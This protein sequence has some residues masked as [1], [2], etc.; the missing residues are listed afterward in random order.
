[1]RRTDR[2]LEA[3]KLAM[4]AFAAEINTGQ[5]AVKG[6]TFRPY[7][8]DPDFQFHLYIAQ[9]AGN[10]YFFDI[11]STLGPKLIPRSRFQ[12]D[13]HQQDR[14]EYLKRI[15]HEHEDIFMA[16]LRSDPESSR[17]AVRNHL[18]KSRERM[19]RLIE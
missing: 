15:N 19:R 5:P 4:Q 8:N 16:I 12:V 3:M 1:M 9:A 18:G 6:T 11:L 14:Q 7:L 10:Q 17:A 13:E 2:H